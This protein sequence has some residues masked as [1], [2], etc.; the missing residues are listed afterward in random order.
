MVVFTV[1][2]YVTSEELRHS[3]TTN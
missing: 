3:R 2:V 1:D